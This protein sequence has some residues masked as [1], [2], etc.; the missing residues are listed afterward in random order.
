MAE[1]GPWSGK[2]PL[3]VQLGFL[4]PFG[5]TMAAVVLVAAHSDMPPNLSFKLTLSA[6][7]LARPCRRLLEAFVKSVNTNRDSALLVVDDLKLVGNF[8]RTVSLNAAIASLFESE[9]ADGG[10]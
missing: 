9:V 5:H 7:M 1:G 4:G 8:G 3:F 2:R 10:V 6:K